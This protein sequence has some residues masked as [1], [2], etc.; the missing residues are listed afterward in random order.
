MRR[1]HSREFAISLVLVISCEPVKVESD[2]RNFSEEQHVKT[3]IG[4]PCSNTLAV[5]LMGN[6]TVHEDSLKYKYKLSLKVWLRQN[7]YMY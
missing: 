7:K 1:S 2:S 5:S 4:I 6:Q 3:I